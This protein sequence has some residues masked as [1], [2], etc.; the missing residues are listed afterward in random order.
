MNSVYEIQEW[1][2][3]VKYPD[4]V[5]NVKMDDTRMYLQIE[6]DSVCTVTGKKML[7]K[8]RKW[9]ISPHMT[10]S[11]VV[12]TAFLAVLAALEHETRGL[13]LYKGQSIF[14]PHYDVDKL[15]ELRISGT[16]Q[17]KRTE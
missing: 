12:Q 11:E 3:D 7:W 15:M 13:F 10:K 2:E 9:F 17:S 8:G 4:L 14:S 16:S 6:C 5:F 1:L